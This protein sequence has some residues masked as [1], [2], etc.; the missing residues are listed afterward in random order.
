M[1]TP[2][3]EAEQPVKKRGPKPKTDESEQLKKA[4]AEIEEL[5]QQSTPK[6][7]AYP[8]QGIMLTLEESKNR[9]QKDMLAR[10]REAVLTNKVPMIPGNM[11][12][13][14][15]LPEWEKHLYHVRTT[16]EPADRNKNTKTQVIDGK[17]VQVSDLAV[18][19]KKLNVK[20]FDFL[21][22]SQVGQAYNSFEIL[23]DPTK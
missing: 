17:H 23:H 20:E 18:S 16:K 8:E 21:E 7:S 9:Q 10:R 19:I 1:A 2:Q 22:K 6:V 13:S 5:K 4:L 12:E 15:Q 14:Y 3:E 11:D